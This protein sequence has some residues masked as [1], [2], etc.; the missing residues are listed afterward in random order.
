MVLED[1]SFGSRSILRLS[2]SLKRSVSR[3]PSGPTLG[4]SVKVRRRTDRS[5]PTSSSHPQLSLAMSYLTLFCMTLVKFSA[6]ALIVRLF[7]LQDRVMRYGV[8][9]LAGYNSL[10]FIA[11]FLVITLQCR[12]ISSWWG[13]PYLCST[14]NAVSIG[15][16]VVDIVSDVCTLLLPQRSIWRLK[17][18]S[19]RRLGLSLVFLVGI[20]YD[21]LFIPNAMMPPIR[22]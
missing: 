18:S 6:L 4:R 20:L 17:M 15:I 13:E 14:S 5:K 10:A 3:F 2:F 16:G 11:A 1:M 19:K 7:T 9:A 12:P 22:S 21:E 8:Y